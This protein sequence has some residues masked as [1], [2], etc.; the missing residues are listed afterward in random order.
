MSE[1]KKKKDS[2]ILGYRQ[3][4]VIIRKVDNIPTNLE[5][6]ENIL[7]YGEVTGHKHKII[8]GD[9]EVFKGSD[10]LFINVKSDFAILAHGS[11]AQLARWASGEQLDCPTE[12]VHAPQKIQKGLYESRIQREY[13]PDGWREVAD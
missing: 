12:D 7:A 6:N 5:K 3:G 4:D 2:A 11:D 8:K 10:R 9:V 13:E 1:K